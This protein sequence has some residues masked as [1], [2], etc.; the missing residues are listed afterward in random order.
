MRPMATKVAYIPLLPGILV[1]LALLLDGLL[2]P[3]GA[4]YGAPV[5]RLGRRFAPGRRDP[6]VIL[7][8]LPDAPTAAVPPHALLLE[9]P[10]DWTHCFAGTVGGRGGAGSRGDEEGFRA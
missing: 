10:D 6:L 2:E 3:P 9:P 4:V 5:R 1:L 7:I 8:P